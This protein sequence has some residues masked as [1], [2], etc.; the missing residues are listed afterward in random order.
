MKKVPALQGS[1]SACSQAEKLVVSNQLR[2]KWNLKA[3]R[4]CPCHDIPLVCASYSDAN[5]QSFMGC[6]PSQ[7]DSQLKG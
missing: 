6:I 3:N 2:L 5:A 4:D 1:S 7:G